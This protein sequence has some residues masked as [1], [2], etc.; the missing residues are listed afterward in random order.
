[1]AVD[2]SDSEVIAGSLSDA[3]QFGA[4]FDRHYDAIHRYLAQRVGWDVANDLAGS[5]FT[6][7]LA[8]RARFDLNNGGRSSVALRHCHQ[9]RS[10]TPARSTTGSPA[11]GRSGRPRCGPLVGDQLE[12][13]EVG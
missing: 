7:A 1:M 2:R 5:V 12:R 8:S 13:R 11:A 4:I 3:A 10:D 6:V 9:S